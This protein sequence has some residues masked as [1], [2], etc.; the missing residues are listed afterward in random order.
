MR[1]ERE[2]KCPEC[3]KTF[4]IAMGIRKTGICCFCEDKAYK[5]AGPVGSPDPDDPRTFALDR[6]GRP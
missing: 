2:R 5:E 4:T 1:L 3:R 6:K